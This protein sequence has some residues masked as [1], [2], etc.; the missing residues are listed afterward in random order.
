[1]LK[2]GSN[3]EVSARLLIENGAEDGQRTEHRDGE[4]EEH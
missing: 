4:N 3:S 1:M 2:L